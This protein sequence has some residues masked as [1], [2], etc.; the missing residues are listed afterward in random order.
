MSE[1]KWTLMEGDPT[2]IVQ[3]VDEDGDPMVVAR[4]SAGPR[5]SL[6]LHFNHSVISATDGKKN[7]RLI[8]AAPA[9]YEALMEISE[10]LWAQPDIMAKLRPLMG[11]AENAVFDA[12]SAALA[13]A[14]GGQ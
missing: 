4:V 12:C 8:A 9:L 7:A 1:P 5:V 11:P 3:G 6:G 2:V 14:K 13:K 10:M